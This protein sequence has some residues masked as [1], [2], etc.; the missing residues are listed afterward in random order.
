MQDLDDPPGTGAF[1]LQGTR[2]YLVGLGVCGSDHQR[3]R[4]GIA[5]TEASCFQVFAGRLAISR[6]YIHVVEY[7]LP[8]QSAT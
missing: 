4:A 5:R 8:G 7:G 2:Q 1:H 3:S 6:A